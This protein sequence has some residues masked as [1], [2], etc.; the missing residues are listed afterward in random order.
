MSIKNT[1]AISVVVPTY[2][3]SE[4]I[5]SFLEELQNALSE[6]FLTYEII[7][8][9][10]NIND[11]TFTTLQKF[12]ENVH[13]KILLCDKRL[14][15]HQATWTG[16]RQASGEVIITIDDDGEYLPNQIEVL[17]QQWKTSGSDIVYGIPNVLKKGGVKMVLYKLYLYNL[18]RLGENR[19]SSF[20]LLSSNFLKKCCLA[21]RDMVNIDKH[22]LCYNPK[23]SYSSVNYL[24]GDRGRYTLFDY[25][26]ALYLAATYKSIK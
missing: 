16:I 23:I 20:R 13:Y 15:Q 8:V 19:K 18:K 2:N 22:L 11:E 7:V 26:R 6:T 4:W 12:S 14:G 25:I 3:S 9:N 24:P 17:Y 10:D 1:V 5:T 21:R